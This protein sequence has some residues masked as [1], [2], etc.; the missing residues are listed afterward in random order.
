MI[1]GKW[2]KSISSTYDEAFQMVLI[3]LIASIFLWIAR[4]ERLS[5]TTVSL[6]ILSPRESLMTCYRD[7]VSAAGKRVFI[8]PP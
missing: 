3:S 5:R 8:A 4:D 2:S 6:Q 7:E 1:A